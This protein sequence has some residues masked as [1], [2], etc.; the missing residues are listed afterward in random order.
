MVVVV[1][2]YPGRNSTIFHRT[3]LSDAVW[4]KN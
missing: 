4:L 3:L 2:N 1:R